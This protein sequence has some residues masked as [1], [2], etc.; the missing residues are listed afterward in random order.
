M[1]EWSE[2][3]KQ[4]I[5]WAAPYI[6]PPLALLFA[7]FL[8]KFIL[9]NRKTRQYA[10]LLMNVLQGQL[11]DSLGPEKSKQV[12]ELWNEIVKETEQNP[13]GKSRAYSEKYFVTRMKNELKLSEDGEKQ[14]ARI[15]DIMN[16]HK[17][18]NIGALSEDNNYRL[19]ILPRVH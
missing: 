12:L 4:S 5:V 15:L 3:A 13:S 10:K 8:F 16:K 7:T 18:N 9:S 1:S 2:L 14:I 17:N 6:V 19:P 11:E